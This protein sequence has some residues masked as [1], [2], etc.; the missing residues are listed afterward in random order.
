MSFDERQVVRK[1]LG[2]GFGMINAPDRGV[3]GAR[4]SP[5]SVANIAAENCQGTIGNLTLEVASSVSH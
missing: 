3:V 5:G 1:E 4:L 2:Q